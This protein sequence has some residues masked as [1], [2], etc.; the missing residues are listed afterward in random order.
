MNPLWADVLLMACSKW[1]FGV[2]K[3]KTGVPPVNTALSHDATKGKLNAGPQSAPSAGAFVQSTNCAPVCV[4]EGFL[5]QY[6]ETSWV[7]GWKWEKKHDG[8][9]RWLRI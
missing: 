3:V 4:R 5:E 1:Y 8:V 7:K 2:K 6:H 9:R